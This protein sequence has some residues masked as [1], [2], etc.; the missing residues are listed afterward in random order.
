MSKIQ[1][2][3]IFHE[4]GQMNLQ[5]SELGIQKEDST[6]S[7]MQRKQLLLGVVT[8]SNPRPSSHRM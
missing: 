8:E 1:K 5:I 4:Q 7:K 2:K 3:Y 6:R